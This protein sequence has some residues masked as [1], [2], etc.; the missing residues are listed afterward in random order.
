MR[1][2]RPQSIVD[3]RLLFRTTEPLKNLAE[4][5]NI[6]S[7]LWVV[8]GKLVTEELITRLFTDLL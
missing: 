1:D 6:E 2:D 7:L 8:Y 5:P 3:L 4:F